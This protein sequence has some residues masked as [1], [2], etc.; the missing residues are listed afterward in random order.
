M[1]NW[2][3]CRCRT[4]PHLWASMCSCMLTGRQLEAR[5][6]VQ[7]VL[8]CLLRCRVCFRARCRPSCRNRCRT[9]CGPPLKKSELRSIRL[10]TSV[11]RLPVMSP[12]MPGR[13][14]QAHRQWCARTRTT[15]GLERKRS[16]G[17]LSAWPLCWQHAYCTH[18]RVPC[19]MKMA[20]RPTSLHKLVLLS[21]FCGRVVMQRGVLEKS[22][23]VEVRLCCGARVEEDCT[24]SWS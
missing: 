14:D 13:R 17:T 1:H 7:V 21:F 20:R 8:P 22:L 16:R 18:C 9:R 3:P 4:W 19:W 24:R 2:Q 10:P 15:Q 12:C 6:V 11:V 5:K 23:N